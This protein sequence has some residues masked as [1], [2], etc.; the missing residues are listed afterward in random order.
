MKE[1][2]ISLVPTPPRRNPEEPDRNGK[3]PEEIGIFTIYLIITSL[4]ILFLGGMIAY[5]WMKYSLDQGHKSNL[6]FQKVYEVNWFFFPTSITLL[7]SLYF[8]KRA[9]FFIKKNIFIKNYLYLKYLWTTG[10][11]FFTQEGIFFS[12]FREQL[13]TLD[14]NIF[15]FIF[16]LLT[17]LHNFHFFIVLIFL[18]V[19]IYKAK[20]QRYNSASHSDL[21]YLSI[22]WKYLTLMWFFVYLFVVIF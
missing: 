16:F 18:A 14:K 2:L 21:K 9:I 11:I 19:F 13:T 6:A 5:L 12:I 8:L 17:F 15:T 4:T 10:L 22:L 7:V 1:I 20:R 3:N